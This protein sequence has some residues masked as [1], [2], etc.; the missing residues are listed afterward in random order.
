MA[1]A[2]TI[3]DPASE[4][5]PTELRNVSTVTAAAIVAAD[6]I[7]IGVFTSLGFQVQ[8]IPSAFAVLLLWVVGGIAALCGALCYAEL[9]AALPRS[10]GE[11]NFLS[12]IYGPAIGFIAGW[13]SATV[14][15][16]APVALAGMAFGEY[17]AGA[18]PG[19]PPLALG[20]G[21]VWLVALVHLRGVGLGGTF[22]NAATALKLALIV[23]LIIAGVALGEA[24][25]ISFVPS[26]QDLGYISG[27]PFAVGLVFVMYAYSG[28]NAATYIAGEVSEPQKSLPRALVSATLIV[29]VLYVGLNAV[30]LYTTPIAAMAGQIDVALIAGTHIF[31]EAGGR[32]VGALI[33][34]GLISSISAMTWIGP[35]VTMVMGEDNAMLRVFARRSQNGAPVV[36]ILFQLAVTTLLLLTRSF[37]AVLEFIQF[38]LTFCSFL[39]VLGVIVLRLKRPDLARSYRTWGYPVTPLVFLAV[40]LFMMYYLVVERPT[41]SLASTGVMLLGLGVFALSQTRG[42]RRFGKAEANDE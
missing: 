35:R 1:V 8:D 38:S 32:F 27:A 36:A 30:F 2:S 4:E 24:Q 18:V 34:L 17:F 40:T 12:R 3:G 21:A 28:W 11:Y 22:H 19:A 42:P 7:G 25:P 13:V 41:E 20:L 26:A 14:G 15:F 16:A 6:M 9:A 31:G 10:G 29:L 5:R 39:A 33:C 37:E 23:V